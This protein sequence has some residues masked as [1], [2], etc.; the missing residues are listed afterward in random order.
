[1]CAY[2]VRVWTYLLSL[3]CV[4]CGVFTAPYREISQSIGCFPLLS[5]NLMH[6]ETQ[7]VTFPQNFGAVRRG[8]LAGLMTSS[9]PLIGSFKHSALQLDTEGRF[10]T[11]SMYHIDVCAVGGDSLVTKTSDNETLLFV[12]LSCVKFLCSVCIETVQLLYLNLYHPGQ[13]PYYAQRRCLT[14]VIPTSRSKHHAMLIII[15]CSE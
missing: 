11:S 4:G 1:M 6:D 10:F 13:A 7:G 3:V 15:V 8:G 14:S 12:V 9:Q 2:C 5:A